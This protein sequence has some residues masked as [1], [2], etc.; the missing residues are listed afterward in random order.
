[1][2]SQI[3]IILHFIVLTITVGNV[4]LVTIDNSKSNDFPI[5]E[6][7]N[8][9]LREVFETS[10]T[11][12]TSFINPV[13]ASYTIIDD[14]MIL[15]KSTDMSNGY[16]STTSYLTNGVYYQRINQANINA[17]NGVSFANIIV[18]DDDTLVDRF[19]EVYTQT[20]YQTIS[21]ISDYRML[22]N[23][24]TSITRLYIESSVI[25]HEVKTNLFYT[26]R[27]DTL[28]IETLTVEQIDDWFNIYQQNAEREISDTYDYVENDLT[29]NDLI[30][31]V[32]FT[33]LWY[34]VLRM[35]RG[36]L[37]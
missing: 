12:I 18:H 9:T 17:I 13:R 26:I 14:E 20:A 30:Y 19:S 10:L 35:I 8:H 21:K 33:V 34:Y 1:M 36:L 3:L 6:L 29:M 23:I 37:S 24:T 15:I 5:E 28:D 25:G 32:L 22:D 27:L 16:I 11:D 7:N 2:F 31:I 4:E